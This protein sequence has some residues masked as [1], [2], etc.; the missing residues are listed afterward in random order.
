MGLYERVIRRFSTTNWFRWVISRVLTPLDMKLRGSRF[1]PSRFGMDAPLCFV[2]VA[3]KKSGEPRTV[4]L[5]YVDAEGSYAVAGTNFG[6]D[7]HP[8]WVHNFEAAGAGTIEIE[9]VSQE[10]SIRR[11]SQ[12]ELSEL[13][14][15]FDTVWPGYKTYREIAPRDI[16]AFLLTPTG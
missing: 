1:A 3:G 10:V 13:W 16:R 15:K 4:P 8:A 2:T 9:D 14:P 7:D 11:L 12:Q 5:L 6:R